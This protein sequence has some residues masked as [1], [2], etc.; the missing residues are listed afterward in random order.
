MFLANSTL[1][2]QIHSAKLQNSFAV[3]I[4][5]AK[6][7]SFLLSYATPYSFVKSFNSDINSFILL[8]ILV[9]ESLDSVLDNILSFNIIIL[10]SLILLSLIF[11]SWFFWVC[12]GLALGFVWVF[13]VFPKFLSDKSFLGLPHFLPFSLATSAFVFVWFRV[14][15]FALKILY[16]RT[17][18]LDGSTQYN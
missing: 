8:V 12:S 15:C 10:L 17:S 14:N 6:F 11:I 13:L 9:S 2:C 16:T 18:S 5:F 1:D 4:C 7:L 3:R